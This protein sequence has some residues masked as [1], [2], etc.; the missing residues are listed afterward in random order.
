[1]IHTF[2][3]KRFQTWALRYPEG[4]VPENLFHLLGEVEV[5]F[6]LWSAAF[7]AFYAAYAGYKAPIGFLESL[8]FT[9]PLFV[10]AVMAVASTRPILFCAERILRFGSRIVPGSR[11]AAFTFTALAIGPLLGSLITEPAAMTVVALLL[12]QIVFSQGVSEPFRYAALGV[13]FVN[14]SVGGTLTPFAAPPV[15]MVAAPWGWDLAYMLTHFGYKSALICVCN[16][17]GLVLFFRKELARIEESSAARAVV[18]LWVILTHLVFLGVI[19]VCAHHPVV[20]M[21]SLLFFLGIVKITSEYQNALKVQESLLVAFFLAGLVIFGPWQ[22]WWLQPLLAGL[23]DFE[24][25][26][27]A[28]ALTA[29]TDNA[30]LTYLGAQV[31]GLS[32]S[33]KLALV[34]GAVAGGGLTVIANAPNPAGYAI[35]SEH[36]GPSGISPLRLFK[37]ALLPTMI[38]L[39]A[40]WFLPA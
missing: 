37:G 2:S 34:S 30:A 25:F 31:E 20:F 11:T 16:A 10:F 33:F 28:T 1:M 15:L 32:E 35:L 18:P 17:A 40:L 3:V 12:S 36:F 26:L 39:L 24:V 23:G 8:N 19:V 13:L 4:S 14:I 22:R 27:G 29:I 9:E 5:V 21:G 6:G 38:A 7:L